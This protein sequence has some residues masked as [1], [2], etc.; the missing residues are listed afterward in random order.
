[1]INFETDKCILVLRVN[2]FAHYSFTE[3]HR[4]VIND[5]GNVWMLKVGRGLAET[6]VRKVMEDGGKL[7]IKEPK[8]SGNHYYA[9]SISEIYEGAWKS[10]MVRPSYYDELAMSGV[11][12]KGTWL[13]IEGMELI[14]DKNLA[15]FTLIKGGK[16]MTDIIS[17]TRSPILFVQR[18][19]DK[20]I[21]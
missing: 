15:D 19:T 17:C 11:S 21:S 14:D 16:K 3:E 9:C 6:S 2:D 4:K 7:I 13:K 10:D 8:K 5:I 1:M 20:A 18:K 12:L